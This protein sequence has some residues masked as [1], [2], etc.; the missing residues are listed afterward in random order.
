M[1]IWEYKVVNMSLAREDNEEELNVLGQEGWELVSVTSSEFV[2]TDG[3][4]YL[5]RRKD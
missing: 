4:A 3:N 5:K 1:A 2:D